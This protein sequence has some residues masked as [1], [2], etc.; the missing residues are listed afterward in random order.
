MSGFYDSKQETLVARAVLHLAIAGQLLE[1]GV[2]A[3]ACFLRLFPLGESLSCYFKRQGKHGS[4][5]K[6]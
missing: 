6:S 4:R 2:A 5:N 3:Q 1:C